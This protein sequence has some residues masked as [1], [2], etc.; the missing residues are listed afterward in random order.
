MANGIPG[1]AGAFLQG[2]S[3]GLQQQ[4]QRFAL[5]EAQRKSQAQQAQQQRVQ[6][7]I[8]QARGGRSPQAASQSP[9]GFF[10]TQEAISAPSLSGGQRDALAE[11]ELISPDDAKLIRS[12][13]FG[14]VKR[15][16]EIAQQQIANVAQTAAL[17][18]NSPQGIRDQIIQA[19]IDKRRSL[20]M[21]P[22]NLLALQQLPFA[23][24]DQALEAVIQRAAPAGDIAKNIL[25][26]RLASQKSGLTKEEERVS[27]EGRVGLE[28]LK[29]K[30]RRDLEQQKAQ[31]EETRTAREEALARATTGAVESKADF[32]QARKI[33]SE[34]QKQPQIQEFNKIESSFARIQAVAAQEKGA[35]PTAAGDLAMIFNYMKMLDPGS[36]VRE[37]EFATAA[38]ARG[39]L[40]DAEEGGAFIP[41]FVKQRIDRLDKGLLLTV[42]MRKDFFDRASDIFNRQEKLTEKIES[43]FIKLG[44]RFGLEKNDIITRGQGAEPVEPKQIGRFTIE[45]LE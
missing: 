13:T 26:G 29:Q 24:Q 27:Q 16:Q 2:R 32:E 21:D 6:G 38:K 41:S 39:A 8:E 37:S 36:V 45:V 9:L 20:G 15:R 33:R 28:G 19:E 30:G 7:L 18:L 17:A 4:A 14:D 1:P 22:E 44:S 11:L 35:L 31:L 5:G 3:I 43:D 10:E 40:E 25:A 12:Q 42:K 23:Q 34:L